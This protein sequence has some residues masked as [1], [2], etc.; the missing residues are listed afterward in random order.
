MDWSRLSSGECCKLISSRELK[1]E[2]ERSARKTLQDFKNSH[3]EEKNSF[4]R[5]LPP[6]AKEEMEQFRQMATSDPKKH[7]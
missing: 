7:I 5:A 6:Q 1:E 2:M 4:E 3:P